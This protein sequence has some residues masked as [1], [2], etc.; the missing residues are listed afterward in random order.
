M[1]ESDVV[2]FAIYNN[3]TEM[4]VWCLKVSWGKTAYLYSLSLYQLSLSPSFS[5]FKSSY[6]FLPLTRRRKENKN[7]RGR[8]PDARVP[9]EKLSNKPSLHLH[10]I[11]LRRLEIRCWYFS[12]SDSKNILNCRQSPIGRISL[13]AWYISNRSYRSS[14]QNFRQV[15]QKEMEIK[16]P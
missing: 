11:Y 15:S 1:E 6:P 16:L 2:M 9:Q 5:T 13:M 14:D 7:H 8:R 12:P 10:V 3:L 4:C